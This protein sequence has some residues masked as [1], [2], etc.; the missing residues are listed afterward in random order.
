M[1]D[2]L[3]V[4]VITTHIDESQLEDQKKM[5]SIQKDIKIEHSIISGQT[6]LNSQK[7]VY[8][9][10]KDSKSK[11]IIKMD[12]DM[13][14]LNEYSI[15]DAIKI[16]KKFGMYRVTLPLSDFYTGKD[17][18][19][20]HIFKSDALPNEAN[21]SEENTDGWISKIQGLSISK[22]RKPLFSHGFKAT[23]HQ[24]IRFGMHRALKA[25]NS[26][27]FHP[28]WIVINDLY[29]N[30]LSKPT[31]NLQHAVI[32]ILLM[33]KNKKYPWGTLDN[34][35]FHQEE[36]FAEIEQTK[37]KDL[38][39]EFKLNTKL[40]IMPLDFNIIE[41]LHFYINFCFRRIKNFIIDIV[42]LL[43]YKKFF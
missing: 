30:Y 34:G 22:I 25:M 35:S 39:S 11:I 1:S 24:S 21:I 2:K 43:L 10:A 13:V 40:L 33:I 7:L 18:M 28:H 42:H 9:F 3:I 4:K 37:L 26:S 29:Q 36:F 5:L 32:A 20:I 16:F 14:P 12:A 15:C 31:N 38:E 41:K 8:K 27:G 19:G 23:K 6:K 17:I